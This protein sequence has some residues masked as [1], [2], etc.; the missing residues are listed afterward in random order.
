MFGTTFYHGSIR[1]YVALF[2]T[3]FNDIYINRPDSTH[4][5]INTIKVPISYGPKDKVLARL[6]ADPELNRQPAITLPRISFE[7]TR[8]MYAND[9]KL[10][11]IGKRQ[12]PG[13]NT[14]AVSTQFNP[15][16]Y[17][18]SISLSIIA[19][20]IDDGTR[21]VEQILPFFTPDWTATVEL[22]PEM[23]I[24]MDTPIVLNDVQLT[25]SY[26]GDFETRRA[27]TWDLSFTIKGYLFGPIRKTNIIKFANSNIYPTMRD[28]PATH[29]VVQSG[30]VSITG[31]G[32][33]F[34]KYFRANDVIVVT[35]GTKN[36]YN[37]LV[38]S[39]VSNNTLLVV[40]T[41]PTF[42][43]NNASYYNTLE[44]YVNINVQP[45]LGNTDVTLIS[46]DDD[47]GYTVTITDGNLL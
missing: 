5:Q 13:S 34:T 21:I 41:A 26:E 28:Q 44:E 7:I 40:T 45:K 16:P 31:V 17:D 29:V 27:L 6:T 35:D 30:N 10:N 14:S 9:R 3:L 37:E 19:K 36:N 22:I 38:V 15:V 23:S 46:A 1:K 39:A 25:D 12:A 32:T 4:N 24:Y 8:V 47:Y 43:N 42:T 18:I 2:G 20:N 33:Q 11:T